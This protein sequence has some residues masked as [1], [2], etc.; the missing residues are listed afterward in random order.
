MASIGKIGKK[1]VVRWREGGRQRARSAPT[2]AAATTLKRSVETAYAVGKKWEPDHAREVPDLRVATVAF[3]TSCALRQAPSTVLHSAGRLEI[4]LA[5]LQT[6]DPSRRHWTMEV[7]SGGMLERYYAFLLTSK[8]GRHGRVREMNTAYKYV[9][10]V[11]L[12]WKWAADRDEYVDTV[13]RPR[14]FTSQ[15]SRSEGRDVVAPTWEQMAACIGELGGWQ[16]KVGIVLYFTGLRVQ[17]VMGLKWTD[18][19][20]KERT[21]RIRGALG[22]SKKERK[23]RTIPVSG[24]LVALLATWTRDDTWV[25]PCDRQPGP[26]ERLARS[27][28]FGRAWARAGV[29]VVVWRRRPH[30]T[31]RAGVQTGLTALDARWE[32]IEVL[33]GHALPGSGDLYLHRLRVPMRAAVDLIPPLYLPPEPV[34]EVD[35]LEGDDD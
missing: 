12:F 6:T 29:P 13:P 3:I 25:V 28:D 8:S 23:G 7:L 32:A 4:W 15:I 35:D 27:R 17:Q 11:E 9:N 14:R 30:H 1:Y 31:F 18:Y 26:R 5:W 20:A 16:R 19:D 21:L 33:L 10:T 24:H 34:E 2:H 22:K